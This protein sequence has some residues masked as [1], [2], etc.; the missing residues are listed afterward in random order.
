MFKK[1]ECPYCFHQIDG[2]EEICPVCNKALV[3]KRTNKITFLPFWKQLTIFAIGLFGI[4]LAA[5]LAQIIII[6]VA[7]NNGLDVK[8]L[9]EDVNVN[10]W[11]NFSIYLFIFI[12]F[13]LVLKKDC[14]KLLKTFKHWSVPVSAIAGYIAIIVFNV[15][16]NIILQLIGVKI[17]D[18]ANENSIQEIVKIYPILSIIIFGVIGPICEEL[19]YRVGLFSA[20]KRVHIALAYTVTIIVFALIHFDFTS[21]NMANELL[22]LPYYLF[23]ATVF[24]V[25]YHKFGFASSLSAHITNNVLSFL[26][27]IIQNIT[28]NA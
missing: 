16:Y 1:K 27:A 11:I 8:V 26:T 4:Q 22:N 28:N 24:S 21:A 10:A 17:S 19:T 2:E 20:L 12:I 14:I 25:L 13:L 9:A 23:A 7:K 18:N 3:A 6:F 5:L 15:T